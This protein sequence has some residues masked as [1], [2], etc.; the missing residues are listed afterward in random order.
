ME[1]GYPKSH[2]GFKQCHLIFQLFLP[3]SGVLPSE[4]KMKGS[5]KISID[6]SSVLN[7]L[8]ENN[9][10]IEMH[11]PTLTIFLCLIYF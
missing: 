1:E 8:T 3:G 10:L 6:L 11:V 7:P 5:L 4:R 9:F 2:V